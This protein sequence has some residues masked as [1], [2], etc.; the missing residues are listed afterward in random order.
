MAPRVIL[1]FALSVFLFS[2]TVRATDAPKLVGSIFSTEKAS[3]KSDAIFIG[4]IT[5][6][7]SGG[8]SGPGECTLFGNTVNVTRVLKGSFEDQ[9]SV[10]IYYFTD[11]HEQ[12]ME[13]HRPYI[14][15]TTKNPQKDPD[16]FTVFKLLLV[17]DPNIAS[18]AKH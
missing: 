17:T 18:V 11:A 6:F 5:H 13:T 8:A 10:S 9:A 15:F 7:G 14:F 2:G 3:S 16:Q 4:E 1:L 12:R